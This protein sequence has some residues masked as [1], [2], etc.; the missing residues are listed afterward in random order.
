MVYLVK[1][2]AQSGA[3]SRRRAEML[4]RQCRV[5]VN[6]KT[7]I[8]PAAMID[9]E[10]DIVLVNGRKVQQKNKFVY[11][12]LNKPKGVVS[13]A[14]DEKKRP[15][16][17][18]VVGHQ[19][20]LYPVG[21]LDIDTTGAILLTNDGTLTNKLT[22]PRYH[23]PKTYRLV[24][25]GIVQEKQLQKFRNGIQLEDGKTAPADITVIKQSPQKT[26]LEVVLYEGKKR[27]IRRMCEA[28]G[29]SLLALQ[30]TAIGPLQI[31]KL[32]LGAHRP[33][34]AKEVTQLKQS[35]GL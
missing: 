4:I 12:L 7:V 31:G 35:V 6:G 13:T 27:Q 15:T 16:V 8:D 19:Q 9:P 33:L 3:A 11:I 32:P 1:F 10:K 18:K 25:E 20:R 21:R 23:I 24:I 22:H 17:V 5:L 30:R 28:L 14:R 34:S 2:V 29:L 26:T